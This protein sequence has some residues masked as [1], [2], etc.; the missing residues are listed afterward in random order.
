VNG[1]AVSLPVATARSAANG[2]AVR[3]ATS[4]LAITLMQFAESRIGS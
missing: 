4:L 2:R 1:N 3:S